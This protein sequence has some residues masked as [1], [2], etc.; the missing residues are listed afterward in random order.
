M[1]TANKLTLL[2][3]ALIPV[4]LAVLYI[5]FPGANY[6][7][8]AIFIAAGCTDFIDG[9]I[10]RSRDMVKALE[11]VG[12]NIKYTEYP[13]EGHLI[14]DRVYNEPELFP[15]LFSQIKN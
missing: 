11:A 13:E 7:A 10:A 9:Y 1:N 12:G 6:V 4:F 8:M 3:V 15:W 14:G 2:R 5:G